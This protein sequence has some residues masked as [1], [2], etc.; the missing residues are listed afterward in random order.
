[1]K[2]ID[3][4]WIAIFSMIV[5]FILFAVTSV[6]FISEITVATPPT[7]TG[8]FKKIELIDNKTILLDIGQFSVNPDY[9]ECQISITDPLSWTFKET[10]LDSGWN[11]DN[12][13]FISSFPDIYVN[14][15]D[16]DGDRKLSDGDVISIDAMG[17]YLAKGNWTVALN[18]LISGGWPMVETAIEVIHDYPDPYDAPITPEDTLPFGP[19]I[20]A[21][22]IIVMILFVYTVI[23]T[24]KKK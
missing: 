22:A 20:F 13:S 14:I 10:P 2:S 17:D 9:E 11:D 16:S 4:E 8:C 3:S 23:S 12:Y 6:P 1:M 24:E 18:D 15:S 7:P 5:I 21:L 19:L